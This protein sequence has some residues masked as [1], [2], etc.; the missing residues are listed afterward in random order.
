[1]RSWA[2]EVAAA[3]GRGFVSW[4]V[5]VGWEGDNR[6]PSSYHLSLPEEGGVPGSLVLGSHYTPAGGHT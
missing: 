6:S 1:M 2:G 3:S 5:G 4:G